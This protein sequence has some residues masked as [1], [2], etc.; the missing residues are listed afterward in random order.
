[1]NRSVIENRTRQYFGSCREDVTAVYLFGSV[2]R[3]DSAEDSDFDGGAPSVISAHIA[4]SDVTRQTLN[5]RGGAQI[6]I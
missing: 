1:M 3:G 5:T 4:H 2:S 6:T